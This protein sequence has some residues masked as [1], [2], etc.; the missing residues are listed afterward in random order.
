MVAKGVALP[1]HRRDQCRS[2]RERSVSTTA[3]D[4]SAIIAGFYMYCARCDRDEHG[5]QRYFCNGGCGSLGS[6]GYPRQGV[7]FDGASELLE[8]P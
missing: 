7:P 8:D 5:R 6:V 3:V 4:A 2:R 1:R